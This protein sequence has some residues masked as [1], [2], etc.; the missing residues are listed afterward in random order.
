MSSVMQSTN[1]YTEIVLMYAQDTHVCRQC[2]T[3]IRCVT[4]IHAIRGQVCECVMSCGVHMSIQI[5]Y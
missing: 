3:C 2:V 4:C 5:I 1:E